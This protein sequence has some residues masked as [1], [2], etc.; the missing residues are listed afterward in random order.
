[1]GAGKDKKDGE[2]VAGV[3]IGRGVGKPG[4][5]KPD[6]SDAGPIDPG[7]VVPEGT[8]GPGVCEE[9]GGD[10]E[11]VAVHRGGLPR[12]DIKEVDSKSACPEEFVALGNLGV[13][14]RGVLSVHGGY[15]QGEGPEQA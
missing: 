4:G 7:R 5:S 8:D 13:R 1:L 15:A 3:R 11:V 14:D 9:G 10:I 2:E 12:G 6:G